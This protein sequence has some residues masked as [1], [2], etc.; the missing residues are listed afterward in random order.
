MLA[1][2]ATGQYA[3]STVFGILPHTLGTACDSAQVHAFI[4]VPRPAANHA[5]SVSVLL[6]PWV[7][8]QAHFVCLNLP[9]KIVK[10]FLPAC[11]AKR[12]VKKKRVKTRSLASTTN[13]HNTEAAADAVSTARTDD[14][15]TRRTQAHAPTAEPRPAAKH[16][17][18]AIRTI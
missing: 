3:R 5:G 18:G 7:S 8:A 13:Q 15:A 2:S 4:V 9:M 6:L 10:K 12:R 16:A 17:G 14:A 11:G 1:P